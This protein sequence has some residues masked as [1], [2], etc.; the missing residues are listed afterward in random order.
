M[1]DWTERELR[2]NIPPSDSDTR[3]TIRSVSSLSFSDRQRW[4]NF[5]NALINPT[6]P[7]QMPKLKTESDIPMVAK[8]ANSQL[9]ISQ[10]PDEILST[11][12]EYYVGSDGDDFDWLNIMLV[13][14]RWRQIAISTPTLWTHVD[15]TWKSSFIDIFMQRNGTLPLD[16][17]VIGPGSSREWPL[18][19]ER[20]PSLRASV[21]RARNLQLYLNNGRITGLE[22]SLQTPTPLLRDLVL[23]DVGGRSDTELVGGS[24]SDSTLLDRLF[25]GPPKNIEILDISCIYLSR[26]WTSCERLRDLSLEPYP[27]YMERGCSH[28]VFSILPELPAL[29]TLRFRMNHEWVNLEMST[30]ARLLKLRCLIFQDMSPRRV[31]LCLSR[32]NMPALTRLY[33][34]HNN[35]NAV[36]SPQDFSSCGWAQN[37]SISILMHL[38]WSRP[39]PSHVLRFGRMT[40]TP[41]DI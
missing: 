20:H 7:N 39:S 14:L 22:G 23:H 5:D 19:N 13:C 40:A 28:E 41:S 34:F 1:D 37:S 29:E 24:E 36:S 3:S 6:V 33:V 2:A 30:P 17:F 18:S 4:H 32:L 35:S 11:V 25:C 26:E 21:G 15:F 27:D 16:V 31:G 9:S 38:L 8:G 12:F 10:L